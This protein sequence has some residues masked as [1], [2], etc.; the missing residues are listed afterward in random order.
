MHGAKANVLRMRRDEQKKWIVI[1]WG[2][3]IINAGHRLDYYT[4]LRTTMLT[5]LICSIKMLGDKMIIYIYIYNCVS[6]LYMVAFLWAHN[7]TLSG[8][9]TQ[10]GRPKKKKERQKKKAD[11]I[12]RRWM[13]LVWL[14]THICEWCAWKHHRWG[15]MAYVFIYS[16]MLNVYH[17][18]WLWLHTTQVDKYYN[19]SLPRNV[20]ATWLMRHETETERIKID[21]EISLT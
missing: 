1:W 2:H 17:T 15:Q 12:G 11:R 9:R 21:T 6:C 7:T 5:I 20:V 19:R 14:S 10:S 18:W 4:F 16:L 13:V 8:A 3:H